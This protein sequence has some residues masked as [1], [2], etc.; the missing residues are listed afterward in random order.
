M[1]RYVC[2]FFGTFLLILFGCG[3]YVLN[4]DIL[5]TSLTLGIAFLISF[6][7]MESTSF[8]HLNPAVSF[9]FYTNGKM[10][11]KEFIKCIVAQILGG[12]LGA[13]FLAFILN[14][15]N[16]IGDFRQ[17]SMGVNSY[18][19]I[20]MLGAFICVSILSLFYVFT[21]LLF[22][23][24]K[25]YSNISG[26]LIALSLILVNLFGIKL[27]GISVNPA[28]SISLSLVSFKYLNQLWL[29]ILAPL[30]GSAIASVIYRC[31]K[32]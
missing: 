19:N 22:T 14:N 27:I 32:K 11:G 8:C 5:L 18:S 29:F 15:I 3:V 9:A 1:K 21:F 30:F 31:S 23:D 16:T 20:T 24:N 13:L 28:I 17:T 25:K 7:M 2:E 4:D 10:T 6:Y 26:I 12:I